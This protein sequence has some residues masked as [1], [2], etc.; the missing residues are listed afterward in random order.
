MPALSVRF[1]LV[2][3]MMLMV[4]GV[5]YVTLRATERRVSTAFQELFRQQFENQIS[6]FSLARETRLENVR[7]ICSRLAT[8]AAVV[9][10]LSSNQVDPTTLYQI[11]AAE[12]RSAIGEGFRGP[13]RPRASYFGFLD[14]RGRV[15][16]PSAAERAGFELPENRKRFEEQMAF[17]RRVLRTAYER[18]QE[19]GYLPPP[20]AKDTSAQPHE[21]VLTRIFDPETR[22]LRGALVVGFPLPD[23]EQQAMVRVSQIFSGIY[24]ANRLYSRTIPRDMLGP[25]ATLMKRAVEDSVH[26]QDNITVA[27]AGVPHR[28]FYRL[29]NESSE[30]PPAYQVCLY[31]LHE[32]QTEQEA[33]R[34]RIIGV[35]AVMLVLA[36]G[37]SLFIAHGFYRP[38]RELVAGTERIQQE[39]YT[40]RVPVRGRDELGRL[41]ESFNRMTEGLALK[42]RYSH[43]LN[44]VADKSVAE[45]LL[46]GQVILGGEM[47]RVTVLF[48]DIRGFTALTQN[49]PAH[50]TVALL[51]EHMT[52]LTAVVYRHGGV[53]DKFVGDMIMALFGAPQSHGNDALN[54]VRCAQEMIARRQQLNENAA[55][56]ITVGI[57]IATGEMVAGCMG[58]A[59]RVNYTVIGERVNLAARLSSQAGRMEVIVDDITREAVGVAAHFERLPELR[60]KGFADA[61][62]AYRLLELEAAP[63]APAA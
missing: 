47:R 16:P 5:T 39:D 57:G 36:L 27:V 29:L 46:Q 14:A 17:G 23:L 44:L 42:E 59:D 25:V 19:V 10:A 63:T 40:V 18:P 24:V 34:R 55:H 35:G 11:A 62:V 22:E 7:L 43:L 49:M 9:T 12:L 58:S 61:V 51:N 41:A 28:L 48:C 45:R 38:I 52:A 8:N 3:A 60:L 20:D 31:S 53:V 30:F 50:E 21:I 15:I 32:V 6:F 1:K 54:A 2:I 56:K 4:A 13:R 26:S 33:M 37:V